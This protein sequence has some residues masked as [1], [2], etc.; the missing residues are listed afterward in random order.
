VRL[1]PS[2]PHV[3]RAA[4]TPRRIHSAAAAR[5]RQSLSLPADAAGKLFQALAQAAKLAENV[6]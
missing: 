2:A 4:V 6:G 5:S 1:L 3:R